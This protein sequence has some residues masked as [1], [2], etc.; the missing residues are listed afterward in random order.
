MTAGMALSTVL[1]AV[2]IFLLARWLGPAE[3][4]LYATALAVTIIVV[5]SVELAISNSIIKFSSRNRLEDKEYLNYGF[6]LKLK[7]GIAVGVIFAALSYYLAGWLHPQLKWPL[8]FSALFIPAAFWSRFPRSIL[9]AQKRFLADSILENTTSAFR[10][11]VIAWFYYSGKLTVITGLF[12]YLSGNLA[13]LIA[14]SFM[15]DWSFIGVKV[16]EQVQHRFFKFQK[17]LTLGFIVAAIHSRIDA[18]M[19]LK[20]AG[21]QAAG[22]Y[23]AAFRFFM[24]V[25]QMASVLSLVFAPRFASFPDL[26]TARIYLYKAA[27]LAL[28]ISLGVLLMLPLADWL[29]RLIFGPEYLAAVWPARWLSLGFFSFIAGS[30]WVAFLLYYAGKAKI[31]FYVNLLQLS[32]ILSLNWWLIPR[33][34][35]RG[36]AIASAITLVII[37]V[38]IVVISRQLA[39]EKKQA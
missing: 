32:L 16:Q 31:F 35:A 21:E 24:P 19:L 9:K 18:V 7:L 12:G 10:L 14:G 1:S 28:V 27:R 30:P 11:I 25:V 33:Y 34:Q 29:V 26:I 37:N 8:V 5:D 22:I 6:K 38:L 39:Y 15:I 36:A 20:L 3:F 17:W 4:G 23:Q 13:A 2:S